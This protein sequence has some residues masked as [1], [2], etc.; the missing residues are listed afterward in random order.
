MLLVGTS[1][2]WANISCNLTGVANMLTLSLPST[3]AVPRDSQAPTILGGW[4]ANWPSQ[5]SMWNCTGTAIGDGAKIN[6]TAGASLGANT[7]TTYSDGSVTYSVFKT[8]IP[9]IGFIVGGAGSWGSNSYDYRNIP[10]SIDFP[11][12]NT[13]QR[14]SAGGKVALVKYGPLTNGGG[15][16]PAATIL[17]AAIDPAGGQTQVQWQTTATTIV[18]GACETP[19]VSVPLG[20][21]LR[22]E[23]SGIGSYT[24][25]TNFNISVN[26]CPAGMSSI[27]YKLDP[28][29]TVVNSSQSVVAVDSTST[30]T[31]VGIQLLDSSGAVFPLSSYKTFANYNAATGG[32]Y[33]IPLQARYYQTGA[34]IDVGTANTAMT[35]TMRYQ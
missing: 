30:A 29:T 5:T 24:R 6:F 11:I 26:N 10:R 12:Q 33:S 31:G 3:I 20:K 4:V 19:N 35:L 25:S 17:R 27:Q 28:T 23:F 18:V 21:H 8:N 9:G 34:S 13:T 16:I 7:G 2:A 15:V 22:A 14:A 32:S 1:T